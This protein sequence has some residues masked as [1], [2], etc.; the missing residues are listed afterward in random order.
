MNPP[1]ATQQRIGKTLLFMAWL[2]V[3][4]LLTLFFNAWLDKRD[5]PNR[6]LVSRTDNGIRE[7]VL[8]R[9]MASHYVAPGLINDQPVLFLI[10]TGASRVSI[11]ERMADRLGL[12][13]GAPL[14]SSTANGTITVYSTIA[15]K[16]TLGN[17]EVYGVPADLN[18]YIEE[19]VVLLGMS[20][21]KHLELV[22]KDGT[23][24]IRQ[25]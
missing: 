6:N 7:V 22:Q 17:I 11:P 2:L 13:Q 8:Q 4:G 1:H 10:D 14:S 12:T 24:T 3:L 9:N 15:R 16:V 18:P 25:H 19:D 5:N 23:L 20:F 21:M